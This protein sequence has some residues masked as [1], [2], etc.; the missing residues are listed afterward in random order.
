[1]RI[2]QLLFLVIFSTDAPV[3]GASDTVPVSEHRDLTDMIC[4]SESY[5]N[6]LDVSRLQCIE[7]ANRAEEVCS[8]R[9]PI[10]FEMGNEEA[11]TAARKYGRCRTTVWSKYLADDDNGFE[12]C[13]EHLVPTMEEYREVV[14]KRLEQNES[15]RKR[16]EERL[17]MQ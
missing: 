3:I 12:K 15:R 5:L 4:A 2:R 10:D 6:C 1:M 14:R 11:Y 7:M 17:Y 9:Y 8:S 13:A 16:L